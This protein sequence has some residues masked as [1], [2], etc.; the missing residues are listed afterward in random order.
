MDNSYES[1]LLPSQMRRIM[2]H[3]PPPLMT[4]SDIQDALQADDS[5][6]VD[7]HH[8]PCRFPQFSMLPQEL[9]NEI[10]RHSLPSPFLIQIN[11]I[12]DDNRPS[13]VH[14]WGV[15]PPQAL[16]ICRES[17]R[18]T[19]SVY[20]PQ[21]MVYNCRV[22]GRPMLC[23]APDTIFLKRELPEEPVIYIFSKKKS[24][25]P[26]DFQ[27]HSEVDSIVTGM[28]I[29]MDSVECENWPPQENELPR[30]RPVSIIQSHRLRHQ[31]LI[32]MSNMQKN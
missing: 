6:P 10:W 19:L 9:Q 15:N 17:R 2:L 14:L 13:T 7:A 1:R 32:S 28:N 27:P 20:K 23:L 18:E 21:L 3:L 26:I 24:S 31:R 8:Q 12:G 25:Q 16:D 5:R 4:L 29:A 22:N 30:R 11:L